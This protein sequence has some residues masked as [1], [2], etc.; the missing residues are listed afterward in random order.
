MH[1]VKFIAELAQGY[2]GKVTQAFELIKGAKLALANF[3]KIQ[4]VY[5]DELATK[6]YKDYKI[7]KSLE[8]NK[9]DWLKIY[10]FAKKNKIELITE[11][12]GKKSLETAKFIGAKLIKIHPTDINNI[13]L[14]TEIKK[15]NLKKIFVG[16]GGANENE[17]RLCLK[18]FSNYKVVLLHGHQTLPTPNSDLNISRIKKIISKFKNKENNFSVGIA[19]HVVPNDKDQIP[20]ISMSIASGAEYIEKHLTTNR[21]FK[22]EDYFSALNPDEFKKLVK[23]TKEIIKILGAENFDLS[24]SEKIYRKAIRRVPI[25]KTNIKKNSMLNYS[26]ISFKRSSNTTNIKNINAIIGN[27]SKKKIKKDKIIFKEDIL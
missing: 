21:I 8:L 27:K 12:F 23:D 7:F 11:I 19:D 24:K 3:A 16:I 17:I 10:N 22:L 25:A 6:D 1:K 9:N 20:I 26:N 5:A 2:E 15:I 14:I 4:I 18:L 13:E